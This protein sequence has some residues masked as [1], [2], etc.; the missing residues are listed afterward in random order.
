[1]SATERLVNRIRAEYSSM[2]GLK[3]TRHQACRLWAV[4]EASCQAA[5]EIL[6]AEGFLHRTGTDKY[7]ALPRPGGEAAGVGEVDGPA[8]ATV[9][10]PHCRKLNVLERHPS[11]AHGRTG[12]SFRCVGCQ[13]V[14]SVATLSA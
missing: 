6:I 8:G 12:L 3:L 7:V 11:D 9:R 13:R 5:F 10:C 4:D 1:M 14:V 2:P